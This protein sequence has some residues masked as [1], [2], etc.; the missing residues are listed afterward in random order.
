MVGIK[1]KNEEVDEILKSKGLKIIEGEAYKNFDKPIMCIDLYGYIY[2]IRLGNLLKDGRTISKFESKNPYILNNIKIWLA[3]NEKPFLLKE[4]QVYKDAHTNLIYICEKHGEFNATWNNM[5]KIKKYKKCPY[6]LG[7]LVNNINC[8]ATTNPELIKYF[9]NPDDCYKYTAN[10]NKKVNLRCFN[11]HN[12]KYMAINTLTRAGIGCSYCGCGVS[13]PEKFVNNIIN[14]CEKEV[15]FNWSNNKR[16]DFYIPSSNM[17]IETHGIQ[18][19]KNSNRGRNLNEEQE[20][21]E[22]KKRLA[23]ENG[24]LYY[25]EIDCRYSTL[26]WLK[27]NCIKELSGYF[28]LSNIEW[29]NI[30]VNSQKSVKIEAWDLFNRGLNRIEISKILKISYQTTIQYIKDGIK[31]NKLTL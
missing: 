28:D 18:H 9:V 1:L 23:I 26:E 21:D 31:Y 29:E 25:I 19:Y 27:E 2:A 4:N 14:N 7:Q 13:I 3:L 20:N 5:S 16:Y 11:C 24:I 17:I 15:S 12:D 10:S 22:F 30:W 8:V 6:C